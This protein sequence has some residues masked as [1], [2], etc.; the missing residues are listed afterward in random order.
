M[1]YQPMV[2]TCA[3]HN[4]PAIRLLNSREFYHAPD[5]GGSGSCL[6]TNRSANGL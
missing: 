4:K 2:F 1:P 6:R 5:T 3:Q